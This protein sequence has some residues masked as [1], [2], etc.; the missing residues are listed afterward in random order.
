VRTLIFEPAAQ[1]YQPTLEVVFEGRQP[2]A[3]IESQLTIRELTA[4]ATVKILQQL[5]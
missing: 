5:P 1:Q 2:E 4:A 3:G